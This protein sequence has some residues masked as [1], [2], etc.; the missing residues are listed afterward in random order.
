LAGTVFEKRLVDAPTISKA[1]TARGDGDGLAADHLPRRPIGH[2]QSRICP[3]GAHVDHQGGHV[4][5]RTIT[6]G[7]HLAYTTLSKPEIQVASTNYPGP[8]TF[9]LGAPVRPDHWARYARAAARALSQSYQLTRGFAGASSGAL[10][11]AGLSSSASV[12][13][14]YLQALASA[15]AIAPTK[16]QLVEL[17]RQLEQ[18]YLGLQNGILD[19]SS[20]LF[21]RGDALLHINTISRQTTLIPDPPEATTA[22]W[23]IAYSGIAREL[24]RGGGFNQRVA[25]SR[26]AAGWLSPEATILSDVPPELFA[27][28][29]AAMPAMLRRRATH[30]FGE[31]ARVSAG[32][33][34]WQA[35]DLARFGSLMNESCASSIHQYQ[36]GHEAIIA[37]HQIVRSTPGVLGSRFSGGGYGGCVIGLV[38]RAGA[39][40]AATQILDRYRQQFPSLAKKAA[41]YWEVM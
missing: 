27:E 6:A 3:L 40:A 21:G 11:G 41:I 17:N 26:S 2:K 32:M 39:E 38:E 31:V 13:L 1:E 15:N 10:V 20:I 36:S 9:V 28:R 16:P 23:L 24:T 8:D 12:G 14:A 33:Q 35:G 29:A 30:F 7:T 4:L 25:E 22:G 37:L 5:G 34:A 19:Q 18:T